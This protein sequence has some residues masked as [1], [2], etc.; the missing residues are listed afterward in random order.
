MVKEMFPEEGLTLRQKVLIGAGAVIF[1][2]ATFGIGYAFGHLSGE[3]KGYHNAVRSLESMVQI[4]KEFAIAMTL[5]ELNKAQDFSAG[6][7]KAVDHLV[8]YSD[9]CELPERK[10]CLDKYHQELQKS[11]LTGWPP[12]LE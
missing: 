4:P 1:A 9:F 10:D 3:K 2:C 12:N 7:R 11:Y 8:Y 5:D 6:I